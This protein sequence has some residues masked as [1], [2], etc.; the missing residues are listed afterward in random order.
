MMMYGQVGPDIAGRL[1]SVDVAVRP[2]RGP[3]G[4]QPTASG[5][6]K[7]H[8]EGIEQLSG[9][10][11]APRNDFDMLAMQAAQS[12][13]SSMATRDWSRIRAEYLTFLSA[14]AADEVPGE[15]LDSDRVAVLKGSRTDVVERWQLFFLGHL[16]EHPESAG[17][18]SDMLAGQPG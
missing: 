15:L 3:A 1:S 4:A 8:H 7:S 16:D 18:L 17:G 9:S 12:L 2:Q 11:A 14:G 13:V 6:S 10:E 5:R